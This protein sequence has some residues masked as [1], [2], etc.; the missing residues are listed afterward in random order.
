MWKTQI[1][2]DAAGKIMYDELWKMNTLFHSPPAVPLFPHLFHS[3]LLLK[4]LIPFAA[5][6]KRDAPLRFAPFRSCKAASKR[7]GCAAFAHSLALAHSLR[8]RNFSR[9]CDFREK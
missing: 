3:P 7:G 5:G 1:F 4:C 2:G 8:E 9:K 6:R